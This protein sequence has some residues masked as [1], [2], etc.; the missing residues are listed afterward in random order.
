MNQMSKLCIV[1]LVKN[2]LMHIDRFLKQFDGSDI[3]IYVIDSYSTDG[4]LDSYKNN[5]QITILTNPFETQA[6]QF[7]WAIDQIDSSFE[8]VLR[9]D[10]DELIDINDLRRLIE[11]LSSHNRYL[12]ASFRRIIRFKGKDLRHGGNGEIECIRIFRRGHGS[13]NQAVMDEK[14]IVNGPILKSKIE[15]IDANLMSM[16]QWINKHN[17]YSSR[18]ALNVLLSY[19]PKLLNNY[20]TNL[21]G[22]KKLYYKIPPILRCFLFFFYRLIFQLGFLDGV[23]G[24]TFIIIQGLFYR[25]MVDIKIQEIEHLVKNFDSEI[26]MLGKINSL[27][28]TTIK[29]KSN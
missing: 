21:V 5:D 18:E 24:M 9:L 28:N 13:A 11:R 27:L 14:I 6:Q 7:N 22:S 3:F 16:S 26:E 8:W 15:I 1:V 23:R 29:L 10:A 17:D 4:S 2:E 20:S 12:G 19:N 25:I